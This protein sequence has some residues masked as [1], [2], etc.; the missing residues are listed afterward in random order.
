MRVAWRSFVPGS[1][2]PDF[3]FGGWAATIPEHAFVRKRPLTTHPPTTHKNPPEFQT[4]IPRR[5]H[6]TGGMHIASRSNRLPLPESDVSDARMD[7]TRNDAAESDGD[8]EQDP[9][10]DAELLSQFLRTRDA[11]AFA[12]IVERYQRLVMGVALRQVGDRDRA[13]DV[14]QA[15]F[16]VLAEK[17]RRIRRPESL[18][19]W[20][21]GTAR[22]IGLAALKESRRH[23]AMNTTDQ[24]DGSDPVL[25]QMQSAWE[26]QVLDEELATLPE[27]LRV[28]LVLHY[29]EGLTGRQVADRL[30]LSVETVEGRLK[31]GRKELRQRLVRQGVGF[32]AVL[33]AF[34]MSQQLAVASTTLVKATAAS[35]VAWATQQPLQGCTANAARLAG[36]DLAAMTAAK[37]TTLLTC[38]AIA[39]LGTGLIGSWALGAGNGSDHGAAI[40]TAGDATDEASADVPTLKLAQA[41]PA[42]ASA[43]SIRIWDVSDS[44]SIPV[45][46]SYERL[47]AS[48][49]KIE[50]T[51]DDAIVEEELPIAIL[52]DF[53]GLLED[54]YEIPVRLDEMGLLDEGIS[55][56]EEL[57]N[58]P[59]PGLPLRDTLELILEN[60]AG[61]ELDYIVEH[62]V[63]KITTRSIAEEHMETVVYELRHLYPNLQASDI[64]ELLENTVSGP[65]QDTDGDGG[66]IVELPGAVAVRQTQRVHREIAELLE[67]V[68][69]FS[70]RSDLPQVERQPRPEPE[71]PSGFGGG[72]GG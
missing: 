30:K 61:V 46:R 5:S 25:Q 45:V 69:Q 59:P 7:S 39:C 14:F 41:D 29:L 51:L 18:P 35:S 22:R 62:G 12:A 36:K 67:Q 31:K 43:D 13:E 20:L 53:A 42:G 49:E 24:L 48:R 23:P 55:P 16:L 64:I 8:G 65:W 3:S 4:E 37:T 9:R 68:E 19:A 66:T 15:T 28:P 40:V 60:V 47:S 54:I 44:A 70:A 2:Y 50:Q 52:R 11:D 71:T 63:L 56:D 34:H 38:T 27:R 26:R 32:G 21:H 10:T 33:A 72:F 6:Y 57:F 1:V 58:P 17:A